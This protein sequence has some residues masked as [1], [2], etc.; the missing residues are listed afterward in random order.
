MMLAVPNGAAAQDSEALQ[1]VVKDV[2]GAGANSVRFA[3]AQG[4]QERPNL[5]LLGGNPEVWPTIRQAVIQSER[6]GYPVRAILVGPM[7]AAPSLEIYA[8]GHHVTNPIDPFEITQ[9][10][11]VTL[12]R[13]IHREYY[14]R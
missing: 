3:A 12:I 13:D 1:F 4:T 5:V 7:D 14:E 9:A 2:R 6:N 11:L 10:E 8:K